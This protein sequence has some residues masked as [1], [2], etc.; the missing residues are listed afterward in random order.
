MK[1]IKPTLMTPER[2]ISSD[3][4]ETYAPWA[5]PT[6]Y[7][8]GNRVTRSTTNRI[9]ERVVPGTT[10]AAPELDEVNW[11]NYG[12]T[13]KWAM[14]DDK[15]STVTS[16][17]NS[18]TVTVATGIIDSV[19]LA[20]TNANK[21]ELIARD[22][23]GGPVIW[24]GSMGLSGETVTDWYQWFFSDPLVRRTKALFQRL[25]PYASMHLTMVLTGGGAISL[26]V[27]GFGTAKDI[28]ETEYGPRAGISDYSKKDKD[29]F[30]NAIFVRGDYSDWLTANLEIDN[31][32]LNRIKRTLAELRATPS[33][34]IGSDL[35]EFYE[36]LVVYGAFKDFSITIPYRNTSYCALDLEGL[37]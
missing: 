22:G 34:W 3:A 21:V 26:G 18:L 29:Q 23:L 8:V 36:T 28:G 5:A 14:F 32:Q 27:L 16:A 24:T 13:N 10:A 2:L 31:L 7:A 19:F 20:G 4:V 37:I 1:V 30:G 17:T 11:L 6:A 12:P 33:M 35:P 25:P 9:Y 15:I